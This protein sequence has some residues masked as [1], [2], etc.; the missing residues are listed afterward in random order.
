MFDELV[1]EIVRELEAKESRGR[2]RG[3]DTK[4]RFEYAVGF[5]IGELWRNSL[6]YPPS[7]SSVNLRSGYYSELPRYRD[8]NLTYRQ[9]KA[10]FKGMINCRMIEVTT[11]GSYM[12]E[13]GSGKVT[14][15]IPTDRLLEKFESLE[16]HPAFQ[17]KS[18]TSGDIIILRNKINGIRQKVGYIDTPKTERFRSNL[19]KINNCFVKHWADMRIADTEVTK[20][21]ARIKQDENKEPVDLS[22][23]TLTRIFA[24]G[25]FEKGGR[26]YR[27]WW[28]NVPSE[29]RKFITIDEGVTTEYDFSQ[30]SPHML[31]FAYNHKLGEEDAYDRVLDGE[32]RD[33]VKQAFNAMVQAKSP[34]NQKPRKINMDG[35][36]MDWR[37]LRQRILDA[38]KPIQ[39][40]FFRAEGNKLQF[41]DSCV[42]ENVMLQFAEKNQVAL[43]I[44]DSF[45]MRE[46]FAGDLEEAMRRAFYDEFQADIPIK[47]EVIIERIAQFDE[48]GNPRTDAVIRDDRKHSQWYDRNTLWLYSRSQI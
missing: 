31:Y 18:D 4:A 35:L 32:H 26:F 42:A 12:R 38:H 20:L 22:K 9:V 6:S 27:G 21:A 44:H 16:G 28:Q 33:I 41:K 19:T 15:F 11:V 43:P 48:E 40:L 10:A 29:Y 30:L 2:A 24:K 5:L 39:D 14:R 8:E 7:E 36:E 47:R 46:G 3:G 17:L 34:L 13:V 45:M 23:R 1:K 37:E 25:S